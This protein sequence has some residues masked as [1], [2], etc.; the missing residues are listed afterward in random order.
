MNLLLFILWDINLYALSTSI[1]LFAQISSLK[2][3]VA[4]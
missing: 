2:N 4:M 3:F 1:I